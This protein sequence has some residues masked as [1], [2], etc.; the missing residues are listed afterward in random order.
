M[1]GLIKVEASF[2][3]CLVG[4]PGVGKLTIA[5]ALAIMTGASV[6]DNHWI[7]DPIVRLVAKD[8]SAPVPAGVWPQVARVR[9]AV[10]DTIA[11]VVPAGRNFIFTYAGSDEDPADRAAFEDYR[12]VARR[13]GSRFIPVRLLCAEAELVRRI[14][15]PERRGKKLTDPD[16]ASHNAK[17]LTPLDLRLPGTL[18]LDVTNLIPEAAASAIFDH[19]AAT[20]G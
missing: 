11:T 14:Q 19:I 8:G 9:T 18:S 5:R 12:D 17:F 1:A 3:A 10:L 15:S 6:V 20:Q 4:F 2:V 7:N 13:R 16:D